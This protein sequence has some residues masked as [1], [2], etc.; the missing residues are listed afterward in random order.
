[1]SIENTKLA[2]INVGKA[3]APFAEAISGN[4]LVTQAIVND[5][6]SLLGRELP[7]LKS[8]IGDWKLSEKGILSTKEGHKLN[9]PMNNPAVIMLKFGLRLLEISNAMETEKNPVTI[10]CNTVPTTCLQYVADK[11][12]MVAKQ[13]KEPANKA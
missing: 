9:L 13:A 11:N 5:I 7:N 12:A 4:P 8:D 1:M 10:V 2:N 6:K 3:I